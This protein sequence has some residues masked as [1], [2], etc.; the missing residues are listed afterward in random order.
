MS[1][2]ASRK[3]HLTLS[4]FV[5]CPQALLVEA[6]AEAS[7]C[8][9]WGAIQLVQ[10]AQAIGG[11]R[12]HTCKVPSYSLFQRPIKPYKAINNG[13]QHFPHVI[14]PF[15]KNAPN[16]SVISNPCVWQFSNSSA[17]LVCL[18]VTMTSGV[19]QCPPMWS[20]AWLPPTPPPRMQGRHCMGAS[21]CSPP[22]R[23]EQ[24]DWLHGGLCVA[25]CMGVAWELQ[26]DCCMGLAALGTMEIVGCPVRC[27]CTAGVTMG[28]RCGD[29]APVPCPL[30]CHVHA[31][32][33]CMVYNYHGH[34]P[35]CH[36]HSPMQ[37]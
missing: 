20:A 24:Q 16:Q 8:N 30:S 32:L 12:P 31:P 13:K 9:Y 10:R 25:A 19:R 36:A 28:G 6:R 18:Q 1:Q 26:E 29:N 34:P 22:L 11:E 27:P 17:C 23:G 5:P 33:R 21:S 4:P 14:L 2:P 3:Y 7:A 37:R 15:L 35:P